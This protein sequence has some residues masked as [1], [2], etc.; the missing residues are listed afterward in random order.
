MR[1]AA[2]FPRRRPLD[3]GRILMEMHAAETTTFVKNIAFQA[4][5]AARLNAC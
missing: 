5:V 2:L 4:I 3:S 1:T